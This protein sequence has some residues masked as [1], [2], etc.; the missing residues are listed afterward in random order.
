VV[1]KRD[2]MATATATGEATAAPNELITSHGSIF[3]EKIKKCTSFIF[4][5][6]C[7]VDDPTVNHCI[8]PAYKTSFF[9]NTLKKCNEIVEKFH[10]EEHA[11]NE[12]LLQE[13][14]SSGRLKTAVPIKIVMYVTA[15]QNQ[16]YIWLRRY[17]YNRNIELTSE[18]KHQ[19]MRAPNPAVDGGEWKPCRHAY[20]FAHPNEDHFDTIEKFIKKC[21]DNV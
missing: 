10:L 2:I 20:R 16:P 11:D 18:T 15:Y 14:I 19:K 17:F 3:C 9:L 4:K 8:I 5:S 6:D 12:I 13:T 21:L 1:A 7:S